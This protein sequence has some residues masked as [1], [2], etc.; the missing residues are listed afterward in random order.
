MD[1]P[2]IRW[3]H[4]K[5]NYALVNEKYLKEK[6]NNHAAGSLEK[7]VENIVKTWEMESS[8]KWRAEDWGTVIPDKF[9]VSAN[10]GPVFTLQDNLEIGNYN[11][12]LDSCVLFKPGSE[13][14]K[15]S[16]ELFKGVLP[17]GFAW[18]L[19]ELL[20]GPPV[21]SFKWRHWGTWAGSFKDN[22]PTGEI[23]EIFGACIAR[24]DENLKILSVEVFYDPNPMMAKLIG[25][26][27]TRIC[28]FTR[29]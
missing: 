24:V 10:G 5:P 18:E 7:I 28:P 6:T 29:K 13:T 17:G 11:I 23:I 21:V 3:R 22:S 12:L 9:T 15:S 1:D 25:F 19:T 27:K 2:N 20:S 14:L 26:E 8:H 16:Y 4:G